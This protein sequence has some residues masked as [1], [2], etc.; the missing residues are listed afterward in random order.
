[1]TLSEAR[2]R[3][4]AFVDATV[5]AASG[6]YPH[7]PDPGNGNRDCRG[8][9][10]H[11]DDLLYQYSID[12]E[13]PDDAAVTQLLE[14]T[15]RHWDA[16]GLEIVERNIDTESPALHA[17]DDDGFS[18]SLSVNRAVRSAGITGSTPCVDPD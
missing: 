17:E 7:R 8:V 13:L 9:S 5:D 18:Y 12:F 16:E 15:R 6:D 2:D 11:D 3:V 4:T 1:M 14:Q 10:G